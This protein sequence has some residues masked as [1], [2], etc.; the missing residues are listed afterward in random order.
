M[1]ELKPV[2]TLSAYMLGDEMKKMTREQFAE[3]AAMLYHLLQQ[4][5]IQVTVQQPQ[6]FIYTNP[7]F[8]PT[9][10]P[11]IPN[12]PYICNINEPLNS[13]GMVSSVE[14]TQL[15]RFGLN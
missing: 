11:A 9:V 10:Y 15:E 2:E 8:N 13:V 1:E 5:E 7:P 4:R 12:A 3:L 14:S 6:P